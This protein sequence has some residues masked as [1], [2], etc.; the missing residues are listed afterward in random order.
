MK[1][2][3]HIF[4]IRLSAM[5]DVAMTVPVLRVL[6]QTYPQLK[7]TVVSKAPLKPLFSGL[8]RC[9][10]MEADVYGKHKG[11]GIF[12]LANQAKAL[13]IDAVA[14]LHNV[15]RSKAISNYLGYRGIKRATIDKGRAEKKALIAAK[16]QQIH[17]LKS[18][19][20]RYADVFEKL[21]YPI[22]LKDYTAPKPKALEPKH[23]Q[24]IGVQPK[25]FIAIAPFAAYKSK[26]YPLEMM[27]EVIFQLSAS[28]KYQVL[29]F[30][31]G[32]SE[33]EQLEEIANKYEFVIN[34]SGILSFSEELALLSNI[35]LMVAMDSSNGHLAAMFGIPVITLWGVTHPYA[36][37]KPFGQPNANQLVS[38]RER[39]PLIPTSIYGNKYPPAY[40]NAMESIPTHLVLEKIH[41]TV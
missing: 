38:N 41:Q 33:I 18:T 25:K 15:I 14:D 9:E 26:M 10:F 29:L 20:Q 5:G 16:G 35:D 1:Q 37:F 21:G 34:V 32:T 6:L 17:Q 36:G 19:Q 24:L 4:V 31:G 28:R 11:F 2:P 13:G 40:E 12:K 39:Y 7:I 22:D 30:G 3:K 27:E 23:H 8:E